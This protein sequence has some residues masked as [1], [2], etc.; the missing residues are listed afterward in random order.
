M[1]E[2][3]DAIR[4]GDEATVRRLLAASPELVR[5]TRSE[6][7]GTTLLNTAVQ[8]DDVGMVDVLL[9]CGADIDQPSDW[10]AGPWTPLQ[11]ALN[12]AKFAMADHLV[13]RG[14][15]IDAHAAAG[16]GRLDLLRA[17]P[18]EAMQSLGGDGCRPLHFAKNAEVVE[19][20]LERGAEI[21]ARD[22]DHGSTAAQYLCVLHP[23]A[24]RALFARGA[25]ADVFSAAAANDHA[26]IDKLLADDPEAL[27]QR[28][29]VETLPTGDADVL[30]ILHFTVGTDA[31]PLHAATTGNAPRMVRRLIE[32]GQDPDTRGGYDD[33]TPLHMAAWKGLVE[34][35][36]AL[37][38]H[39][40][41]IDAR[42]GSIHN[43]TPLGWA[44]V[45]GQT[46]MC[47]LLLDRGAEVL[48][49]F[50]RDAAAGFAGEFRQYSSAKAEAYDA[51][52]KL[53]A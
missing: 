17:M 50:A 47:E 6:N 45:N 4:A 14:A 25:A 3:F 27:R 10:D 22:I 13:E 51:I 44:I 46:A 18:D 36:T 34:G 35:A 43:N 5:A 20:L 38:D 33:A 52:G 24:T 39:G 1:K 15:T 8:A 16:L 7:F 23:E 11:L 31:T 26:T 32:S 53:L 42:S 48:D 19:L 9:D 30:N 37:L 2:L 12:C 41:A 28:I 40:A 29:T 21:D 49:F